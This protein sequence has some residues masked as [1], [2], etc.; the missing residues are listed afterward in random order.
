MANVISDETME[1]VGILAK[2]EL[3]EEEK[4]QAKAKNE[5]NKDL[6]DAV[7]NALGDKVSGVVLSQRLKTHPVCLSSEGALSIEME[8]VLNSM[9]TFI[10]YHYKVR[11]I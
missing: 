4:E 2:L 9:L 8:K 1:Y 6:F 11:M 10:F 7:K 5:E 3:A